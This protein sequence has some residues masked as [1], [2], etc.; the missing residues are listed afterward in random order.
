[1]TC[2]VVGFPFNQQAVCTAKWVD[3]FAGK[4]IGVLPVL[5]VFALLQRQ[6]RK[7]NYHDC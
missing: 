4:I 6:V 5:I 1:M 2:R 7:A 3:L